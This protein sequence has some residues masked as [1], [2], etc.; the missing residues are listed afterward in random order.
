MGHLVRNSPT[1]SENFPGTGA[2]LDGIPR[3][4]AW[5]ITGRGR[6]G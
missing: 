6:A 5:D 1:F 2:I 4:E 3:R